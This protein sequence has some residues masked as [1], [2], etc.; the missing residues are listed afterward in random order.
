MKIKNH[1]LAAALALAAAL[2][3][4]GQSQY[5]V[6]T[7]YTT[8]GIVPTGVALS[9]ATNVIT[10]MDTVSIQISCTPSNGAAVWNGAGK[11]YITAWFSESLDG[12]NFTP[13]KYPVNLL[14]D[15]NSVY[16]TNIF[17]TNITMAAVG[18]LKL[19]YIT[20]HMTIS[21]ATNVVVK[22]A[23]KPKRKGDVQ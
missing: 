17:V 13:V 21:H 19:N 3:A 1:I 22:I 10:K 18:Y 8:N 14:C 2:P 11:E 4:F 12:V 5:T 23:H 15:T 20:N 9:L 6:T 7:L 16:P